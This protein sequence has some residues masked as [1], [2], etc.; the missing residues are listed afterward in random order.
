MPVD[1]IGRQTL[2]RAICVLIFPQRNKEEIRCKRLKNSMLD[3][4]FNI[5]NRAPKSVCR[6]FASPEVFAIVSSGW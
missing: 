6:Q 1:E 4:D 2:L 3:F 5:E